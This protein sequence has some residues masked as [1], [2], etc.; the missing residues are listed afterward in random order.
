M[1]SVILDTCAPASIDAVDLSDAFIQHARESVGD[2]RARFRPADAQSLPFDEESFDITVSGLVLNFVPSPVLAVSEMVRVART[3]GT[4]A[5]YVWDYAGE[6]QLLRSFWDAVVSLDP[7]AADLDEGRRF[8]DANPEPL[9]RLFEDA[10]LRD[11]A[12]RA[13]DI[14][15]VFRDFDD[16]WRPF[17]GGQGPAGA[18]AV[19]LAE[20]L[21]G[22]LR[23]RIRGQLPFADDGSIALRGRA[24]AVRGLK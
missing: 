11:V 3:G 17:L 23:G 1:T 12:V 18:Y 6:M 19:S 22:A 15:M 7:S 9:Q 16:Y 24:W 2:G 8:G 20:P 14:Q 21:R 10:G 4:V 5:A 13:L